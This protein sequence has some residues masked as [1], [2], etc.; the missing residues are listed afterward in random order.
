MTAAQA[1]AEATPAQ[2][3]FTASVLEDAESARRS[4]EA[5]AE[6]LAGCPPEYKISAFL[7][8]DLLTVAR[9]HLDS[10]VG[11]VRLLMQGARIH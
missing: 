4:V 3:E 8:L 2:N 11:G 7:F 6:V 10:T 1:T 5:L 9:A